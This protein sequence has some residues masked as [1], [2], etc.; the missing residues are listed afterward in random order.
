MQLV[1]SYAENLI[2]VFNLNYYIYRLVNLLMI[3]L[4]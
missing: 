4:L 1:L 3:D 2:N